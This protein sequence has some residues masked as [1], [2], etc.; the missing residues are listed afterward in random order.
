[1]KKYF[2]TLM[3]C[4]SFLTPSSGF[5]MEKEDEHPKNSLCGMPRDNQVIVLDNLTEVNDLVSMKRVST[6]FCNLVKET[7]KIIPIEV[8]FGCHHIPP[9]YGKKT[10]N[11][12][13]NP[14]THI[15]FDLFAE[16]QDQEKSLISLGHF[17]MCAQYTKMPDPYWDKIFVSNRPIPPTLSKKDVLLPKSVQEVIFLANITKRGSHP[18]FLEDKLSLSHRALGAN[19][20]RFYNTSEGNFSVSEETSYPEYQALKQAYEASP[21]TIAN[22]TK[23]KLEIK[24]VEGAKTECRV[25]SP[26]NSQPSGQ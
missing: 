15:D 21:S 22:D 4:A 13:D 8:I 16:A 7:K 25:L 9:C 24:I 18:D 1:M 2:L 23:V 5:C 20:Y 26:K 17:T 10:L 3:T 12:Y 11:I 19:F 6:F 14:Y